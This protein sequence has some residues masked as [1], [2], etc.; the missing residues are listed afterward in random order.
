MATL[1]GEITALLLLLY[2]ISSD[3]VHNVPYEYYYNA[4]TSDLSYQKEGCQITE[5]KGTC[6]VGL[7]GYQ[8]VTTVE[9]E[10]G[11]VHRMSGINNFGEFNVINIAGEDIAFAVENG[12]S[13]TLTDIG[14]Y[15]WVSAGSMLDVNITG[16]AYVFGGRPFLT[17]KD[18]G[19]G[20][21]P[22]KHMDRTILSRVYRIMDGVMK[23]DPHINE[24]N[25]YAFD[26]LYST[27]NLIDPPYVMVID[28]TNNSYVKN[29]Y[30]PWNALYFPLSPG[31]LYF[32]SEDGQTTLGHSRVGYP[33]WVSAT[34]RYNEKLMVEKYTDH[35]VND[36]IGRLGI[37]THK[38]PNPFLFAVT[39]FDSNSSIGTP[40]F[41]EM[42]SD[43]QTVTPTRIVSIVVAH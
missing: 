11:K 20:I 23:H 28:C 40:V 33:R 2:P 19:M 41:D 21:K 8:Y 22:A 1:C 35:R 37:D 32:I 38:C 39:N 7:Y 4:S 5:W 31:A 10:Q 34:L 12:D 30:H 18:N 3:Y 36:L 43:I 16:S 14:D 27:E 6:S 24:G 29:H 15:L 26:V 42:V 9:C 13:G 25:A 17:P